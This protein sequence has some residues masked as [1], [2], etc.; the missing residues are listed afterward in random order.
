MKA[1]AAPSISSTPSEDSDGTGMTIVAGSV[2]VSFAVFVSPPPD[3]E[4]EFVC[5]DVAF[6]ATE[7]VNVS[8]G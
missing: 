1:S 8:G 3:T 7:T 4:T 6:D 5:G 2:A